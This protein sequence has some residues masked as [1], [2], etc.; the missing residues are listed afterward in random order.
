MIPP[1]QW[2]ASEVISYLLLSVLL[3]GQEIGTTS[4]RGLH[5][6]PWGAGGGITSNK[7]IPSSSVPFQLELK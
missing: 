2:E 5:S 1:G 4:G 7:E 6:W 3:H